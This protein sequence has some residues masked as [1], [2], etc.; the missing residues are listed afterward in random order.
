M[1]KPSCCCKKELD[2]E[3]PP[4]SDFRMIP[5]RGVSAQVEGQQ[6]LAGNLE[7]LHEHGVS[8]TPLLPAEE[9][10]Q[11]GCSVTYLAAD[12]VFAGY[13]VLP[14]PCGRRARTWSMR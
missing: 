4:A 12:G 3:L 13:I 11:K 2:G 14:T 1:A 6:I 9:A 8:M 7:L 10:V 5:G